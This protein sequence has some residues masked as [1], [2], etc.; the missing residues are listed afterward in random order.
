MDFSP[1]GF[2]RPTASPFASGHA[3]FSQIRSDAGGPPW[4]KVAAQLAWPV[5]D[6]PEADQPSHGSAVAATRA[7]SF[8]SQSR[9][10]RCLA[11]VDA[12]AD[13]ALCPDR[14]GCDRFDGETG[15]ES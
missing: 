14:F 10:A 11:N 13:R 7:W 8:F 2:V 5:S 1:L 6:F 15:S 12:L 3:L 4:R 9:L